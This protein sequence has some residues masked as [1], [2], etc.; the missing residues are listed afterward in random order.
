[1][2]IDPNC[3]RTVVQDVPALGATPTGVV[4][5]I[6]TISGEGI[7]VNSVTITPVET[8]RTVYI[9]GRTGDDWTDMGNGIELAINLTKC[10]EDYL[11]RLR[12]DAATTVNIFY[13]VSQCRVI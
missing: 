10:P 2:D 9:Q 12:A 7:R 1:M 3:V 13:A 11:P 8:A 6:A 4:L 5:D